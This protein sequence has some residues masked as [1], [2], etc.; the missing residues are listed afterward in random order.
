MLSSMDISILRPWLVSLRCSRADRIV[1][2]QGV[3][4]DQAI[5]SSKKKKR[6]GVEDKT[7]FLIARI[8]AS[9][10]SEIP[11]AARFFS[12]ENQCIG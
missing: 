5:L 12:I 10:L 2:E 3:L 7:E 6:H 4:S 1:N 9:V 8:V 11:Q